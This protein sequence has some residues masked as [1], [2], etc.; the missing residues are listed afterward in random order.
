MN[1]KLDHL[2]A[3]YQQQ[4]YFIDRHETMGEK[5]LMAL[6][7]TGGM[8]SVVFAIAQKVE[9][10]GWIFFVFVTIEIAFFLS[11]LLAYLLVA[12]A[13]R[14]LSSKA[15]SWIDEEL[16]PKTG[17]G[18][19]NESLIYYRGI[20]NITKEAKYTEHQPLQEYLDLIDDENMEKDYAKQV[21]ILAHYSDY[22]RKKLER[23]THFAIGTI[24]AG[25]ISLIFS[26]FALYSSIN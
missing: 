20:L 7:I 11:F 6:L 19:I 21:V 18:W 2:K 1:S 13:V 9:M 8:V 15:L 22:K 5:L 16:L 10:Q 14:P 3:I 24:L 23:A 25:V 26:I 17:K 4:H 12:D